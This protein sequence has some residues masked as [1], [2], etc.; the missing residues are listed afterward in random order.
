[1]SLHTNGVLLDEDMIAGLKVDDIALPID[2]TDRDIQRSLR[3]RGFMETFERLPC[4]A[5]AILESGKG[6]GYHTVF[7]AINRQDIPGIYELIREQGFGYWRIYEFNDDLALSEAM[8][9][10]L[11]QERIIAKLMGIEKLRGGGTPETGYT[12][13]LLAHFFLTEQKMKLNG[14]GRIEFVGR[15]DTLEPYFFLDNSGDVSYYIWLSGSKR[16]VAGNV[17]RDGFRAVRERL[18]EVHDKDWELDDESQEEFCNAMF[19]D[20]PPWARYWDGSYSQEE[21]DVIEP[22]FYDVFMELSELHRR[23]TEENYRRRAEIGSESLQ[24]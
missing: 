14:D 23:R 2:S 24:L 17:L 11:S 6:L 9:S 19:W 22:E 1:V 21:I 12:D 4:L 10:G 20:V 15:R 3:G 7:T 18:Q 16:R 8:N 5:S 13:C